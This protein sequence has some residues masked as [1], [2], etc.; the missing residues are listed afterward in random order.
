[1]IFTSSIR[2]TQSSGPV[3]GMDG[4]GGGGGE[5]FRGQV[6][7]GKKSLDFCFPETLKVNAVLGT[8]SRCGV[9]GGGGTRR[10]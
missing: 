3:A 6:V 4:R 10:D 5:Q 8:R 9:G 7:S 2:L 1:M